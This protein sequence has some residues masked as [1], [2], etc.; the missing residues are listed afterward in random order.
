MQQVEAMCKSVCV[1]SIAAGIL[2]YITP[3]N[4][5]SSSLKALSVI[6]LIYS[7]ITSFSTVDFDIESNI[8]NHT[9]NKD[10]LATAPVDIL[11]EEAENIMKKNIE[12]L[13]KTDYPDF[14]CN[15]QIENTGSNGAQLNKIIVYGKYS[16]SEKQ[17][18]VNKIESYAKN[19]INIEFIG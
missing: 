5:L 19:E 8:Y 2:M 7:I 13:M 11:V 15:P 16:E 4:K 18:I 1:V 6:L 14:E 3:K 17:D 9:Y 10:E 12:E